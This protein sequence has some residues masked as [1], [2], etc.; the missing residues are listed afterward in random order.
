MHKTGTSSIQ[1]VLTDNQEKLGECGYRAFVN[2]PQ[3]NA[4][5]AN[6]FAPLWIS[7]QIDLAHRDGLGNIIFSAEMISTFSEEQ[8]DRLLVAMTGH[9][10]TIIACL[11]H[12]VDFLPSRWAQNCVR[13][14][15]Q[16]FPGY[17]RNLT[18]NESTHIDARFDLVID[19]LKQRAPDNTHIVSFNN[20]AMLDALIPTALL[21]LG[22]PPAF[23]DK[24]HGFGQRQNIGRGI[25][26]VEMVRLFNG[27]LSRLTSNDPNSLFNDLNSASPTRTFYDIADHVINFMKNE[28]TLQAEIQGLIEA[29]SKTIDIGSLYPEISKWER[30]AEESAKGRLFNPLNEK[31]FFSVCTPAIRCSDLEITDIPT[32]IQKKMTKLF[33]HLAKNQS[34]GA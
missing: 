29:G 7:Q 8:L 11:R 21:A 15:T 14:D 9:E 17:L 12:W 3:I 31:L 25:K 18:A 20:A 22:L 19:R 1:K 33:V 27:L 28:P 32:A 13:R 26:S 30:L 6:T 4:K 10:I 16:S 5:R 2:A 23:I 34:G 24:M